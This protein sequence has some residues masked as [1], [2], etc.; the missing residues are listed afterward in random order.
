MKVD[1]VFWHI[2]MSCK[3]VSITGTCIPSENDFPFA[4]VFILKVTTV[5]HIRSILGVL[6]L[7]KAYD[8]NND[9]RRDF[10]DS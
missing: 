2:V 3:F 9:D 1:A 5:A 4:Y 8:P 6:I 7:W 10:S